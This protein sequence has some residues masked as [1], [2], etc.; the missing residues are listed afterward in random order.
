[1]KIERDAPNSKRGYLNEDF[2]LFNLKDQRNIEFGFH[3]HDF[4]KIIIFISGNATYLIEGKAYK[5]KPWDILFVSS[6]EVHKPIIDYSIPYERIVIWVN[7]RF[8]EKHNSDDCNLLASFE[9]A[10]KRKFN[11]L[12]LNSEL[13]V[14]IKHILFNLEEE[15]KSSEFGSCILKNSLILQLLVSLNRL[16]MGMENN[17]GISGIEYDENI[18]D[19]LDYINKN[20]SEELSIDNLASWFYMSKYYLMHK[21][22]KQTGY[23][24]HN[25]ILQKRLIMANLL[26]KQGKSIMQACAECGFEDYSS[27][28]RAFKKMFG[29]SPK[30]HYKELKEIEKLL[31]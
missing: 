22:K 7:S 2:Q 14:N 24:I 5:L 15:C 25:Y 10:V 17:S 1:M 6:S 31:Q 11:M 23:T 18:G 4:N 21:F 20:I 30:K 8:L 19:I 16:Y 12:R 28:F 3:H 13:L 29:L 9:L 27:F 26:I